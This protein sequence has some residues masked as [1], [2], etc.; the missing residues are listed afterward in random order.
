MLIISAGCAGGQEV[1]PD[2]VTQAKRLWAQAKI[3]DYDLDWNVRGP[4]N[5]RYFVTVRGGEVRKIESI[6]RDGGKV[7]LHPG[8]PRFFSVD[9]LFHTI[10]D[11]LALRN[12]DKPFG[13]PKGTR[14]VMRFS[15]DDK[16]GYPRWYHRDVMGTPLSIAIEV[17]KLTPLTPTS[18]KTRP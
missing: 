7:E 9:G 2:L 18:T 17:N 15:P 1:T 12:S 11:E 10:D 14:V 6:S 4:N 8:D 13:Q 16:L 3:G 5:A